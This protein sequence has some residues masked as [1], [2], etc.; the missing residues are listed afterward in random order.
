MTMMVSRNDSDGEKE[1]VRTDEDDS[2][3]EWE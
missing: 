3:D 2:E 1:A